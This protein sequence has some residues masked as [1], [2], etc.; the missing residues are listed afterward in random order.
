MDQENY[1]K[2]WRGHARTAALKLNAGWW[3]ES[4]TPVLVVISLIAA[5]T[6]FFLRS[7]GV[8]LI[9]LQIAAWLGGAIALGALASLLIARRKFSN[10]Q[11]TLVRLEDRMHLNNALTAANN[12]VSKWP[13]PPTEARDGIAWNW[14]WVYV[15]FLTALVLISKSLLIPV[16][17]DDGFDAAKVT[18]PPAWEQMEDMLKT[19]EEEEIPDP[20]ALEEFKERIEELKAQP[21]EEWYSHSSMEASDHER[22]KLQNAIQN[23]GANLDKSARTLSALE[24][25][26][27]RISE[28]ARERLLADFG[29]GVKG[30]EAGDLPLNPEL[31]NQLKNLDPSQLQSISQ[32]Q[33]QELLKKMESAAGT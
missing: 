26:S 22:A 18:P 5:C 17:A 21:V 11:E 16:S 15:P 23:L 28:S 1:E 33:L 4:F 9:P 14:R 20:D 27:D 7:K 25:Y 31:M 2:T 10:Q 6:I 29:E 8:E 12:G 13:E 30:L 19:L 32:E 24:K 3:L